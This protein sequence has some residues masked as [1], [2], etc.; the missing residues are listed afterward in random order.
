LKIAIFVG[1]LRSIILKS[2]ILIYN[3]YLRYI[4]R[5]KDDVSLLTSHSLDQ[6]FPRTSGS[7]K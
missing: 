7:K 6:C 1:E 5:F 3:N 4:K 2:D